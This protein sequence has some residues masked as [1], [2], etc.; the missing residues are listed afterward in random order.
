MTPCGSYLGSEL[1]LYDLGV[2]VNKFQKYRDMDE[3]SASTYPF[4]KNLLVLV[5]FCQ[6]I[7]VQEILGLYNGLSLNDALV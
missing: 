3:A 6:L 7:P 4:L 1:F 5:E 2:M